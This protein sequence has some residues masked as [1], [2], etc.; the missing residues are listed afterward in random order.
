MKEFY[1]FLLFLFATMNIKAMEISI[2]SYNIRLDAKE[3]YNS[4]NGWTERRNNLVGLL[5]YHNPDIIAMQEVLHHQLEF[6]SDELGDYG[7]VGIGRDD[8]K[9]KGEYS[10]IFFRKAE[11][12]VIESGTYWLSESPNKP[13]WGWDAGHNRIVTWALLRRISTNDILAVY[14]THFD[15][16]G[17]TA[18]K[19]S[20]K[21]VIDSLA[22][23]L[24]KPIIFT[25]DFNVTPESAAYNTIT[26]RLQDAYHTSRSPH[27]GPHGT[28]S[29]FEV[30]TDKSINRIDYIFHNEKIN[31]IKHSILSD[32]MNKKYPSDHLPVFAVFK[33][34]IN[35]VTE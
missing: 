35:E 28:S 12:N 8:A 27:Y 15:H 7:F 22:R 29:G 4:A 17:E 3:D 9:T 14:N 16:R 10:P 19:E 31:V 24:E 18:Q 1:F 11:F 32:S 2:M 25:G 6:I 21:L 23:H 34:Y 20:A 33:I 13:G 30:C 26:S 5:K